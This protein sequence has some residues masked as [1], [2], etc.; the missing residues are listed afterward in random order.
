[1]WWR[2]WRIYSGKKG[3]NMQEAADSSAAAKIYH[4]KKG[5][6]R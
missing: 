1:V 4:N 5:T 2:W 3:N 6:V